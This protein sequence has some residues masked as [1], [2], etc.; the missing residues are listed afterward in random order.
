MR[1]GNTTGD[2]IKKHA[3]SSIC[4]QDD[5]DPANPKL[6]RGPDA[7]RGRSAQHPRQVQRLAG[8]TISTTHHTPLKSKRGERIRGRRHSSAQ[9][10]R[11]RGYQGGLNK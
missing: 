11:E 8:R 6:L 9:F 1:P 3:K 10:D 7:K 4:N 2:E 5:I